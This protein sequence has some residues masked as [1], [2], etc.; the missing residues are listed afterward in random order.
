MIRNAFLFEARR[1]CL[2]GRAADGC[3][4][5]GLDCF[6]DGLGAPCETVYFAHARPC[7][8]CPCLACLVFIEGIIDAAQDGSE[9]YP[10][11]APGVDERPVQ[12][13]KQQNGAAAPLEV[14]FDFRE[15]VDVVLHLGGGSGL[16]YAAR[17]RIAVALVEQAQTVECKH[18]VDGGD[19]LGI[20]VEHVSEAAG[21]NHFWHRRAAVWLAALD[22]SE[23]SLE[24]AIDQTD[25]AVK[26]AALQ[27][28][29]GVSAD[30]A[31]G[32]LDIDARKLG[33]AGEER[34]RGDAQTG[35]DDAADVFAL[36]GDDVEGGGGAEVDDDDGSAVAREGGDAVD[37]AVRA[38][39]R[40]IVVP[41]SACRSSCR[42][43]RTWG[44]GRSSAR[45]ADGWCCRAAARR[46]RRRWR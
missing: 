1:F 46:R 28:R 14:L 8:V 15:V 11:L 20:V 2:Y 10:S 16:R 3:F 24:D 29:D 19:V 26:K 32:T 36:R 33:G 30:G 6:H 5:H 25:V 9:G 13:R 39:S 40:R 34:V 38:E 17:P 7:L 41:A 21:G 44:G 18:V 22:F 23:H 42:A 31:S 45:R 43:R 4:L 12:G 37:D 27:M 35:S